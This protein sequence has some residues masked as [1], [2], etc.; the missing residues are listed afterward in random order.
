VVSDTPV[1]SNMSARSRT[2][3]HSRVLA[4]LS[5]NG[6]LNNPG[7]LVGSG[8]L[9]QSGWPHAGAPVRRYTPVPWLSKL[10]TLLLSGSIRYLGTLNC[11]GS[12]STVHTVLLARETWY[13]R[14]PRLWGSLFTVHSISL[15]REAASRPRL[16][17]GGTL[18]YLGSNAL[19]HSHLSARLP[20][21]SQPLGLS[22]LCPCSNS[23]VRSGSVARSNCTAH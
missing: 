23:T 8:T 11:R 21:Y 18:L 4:W 22:G 5:P 7:L 6:T 10:G 12:S 20:R 13:S 15:A 14:W 9:R 3:V 16:A 1:H 17:A 2:L 19:A